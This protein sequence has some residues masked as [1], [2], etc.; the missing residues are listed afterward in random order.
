[1]TY[2]QKRSAFRRILLFVLR[3]L[4]LKKKYNHKK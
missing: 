3:F 2:F 1:M 4:G